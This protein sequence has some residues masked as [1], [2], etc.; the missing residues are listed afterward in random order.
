MKN[1]EDHTSWDSVMTAHPAVHQVLLHTK[2]DIPS[3]LLGGTYYLN[4]PSKLAEHGIRLHPF[5]G[6][7]LLRKCHFSQQGIAFQNRY[8]ETESYQKELKKGK[9]CYRGI[10][11]LPYNNFFQ[12]W[13]A[14]TYKNPANTSVFPWQGKLLCGY[15]G[16]WPHVVHPKDLSTHG[17]ET[18]SNTLVKG[19]NFLAHTRYDARKQERFGIS[20][21]P[22]KNSTFYIH[23]YAQ[24]G[25][26]ILQ[27]D[28]TQFG[29]TL[30]HDFL[31]SDHYII[32]M[33]NPILPD[34]PVLLKAL[35]GV[36]PM[37]KAVHQQDR[38][39]R[40]LLF[41]RTGGEP[42]VINMDKTYIAFHHACAS[43]T[44]DEE[45]HVKQITL[46]SC[47]F[48]SYS[49]FGAEFGYQGNQK[50]YRDQF[51]ATQAP[52][53][54]RKVTIDLHNEKCSTQ[55]VSEW[56]I[57]FPIIHPAGDGRGATHVYGTAASP[58]GTFQP[59][60]TFCRIHL[61]TGKE[62]TWKSD[63]GYLGEGYF[64]P[65]ADTEQEGHIILMAYR[66]DGTDL[67]ILDADDIASG[68]I[69]RAPL[70]DVF[71]YGF[72]GYFHHAHEL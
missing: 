64:V 51:S 35:V 65:T 52:P 38:P 54:L 71:P 27:T 48:D 16:G 72:H 7:G 23:G 63:C 2:G 43:E 36:E 61:Q 69:L 25:T 44:L 58:K 70:P 66:D 57:D 49:D 9:I 26:S 33:E 60:D 19:A 12:N 14:K 17:V 21:K 56:G 30:I 31:I 15:E 55:E 37:I 29:M 18:F 40:M 13:W 11:G 39:A 4:G 22:G 8:I 68:P 34:I 5:D 47:M 24:D 6:H 50:P 10:G 32:V 59:F 42:K 3:S 67:L 20:F 28:Y 53:K 1:Q 62:D 41:P 46:F 45:G